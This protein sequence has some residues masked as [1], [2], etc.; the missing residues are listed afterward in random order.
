MKERRLEKSWQDY[1]TTV[2]KPAGAGSIQVIETRRAFY[3]GAQA[4]LA[5]MVR[6]MGPGLEP[7]DADMQMMD[8]LDAELLEFTKAVRERR[9]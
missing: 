1:F 3:A 5:A 9:A 8:D 7:T 2:L 6:S 4:L